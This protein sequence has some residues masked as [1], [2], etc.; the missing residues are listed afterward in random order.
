MKVKE[1]IAKLLDAPMDAS[2]TVAIADGDEDIVGVKYTPSP[3]GQGW[4]ELRIIGEYIEVEVA[5]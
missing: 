3:Y 4:A 1:L 2:V 5:P